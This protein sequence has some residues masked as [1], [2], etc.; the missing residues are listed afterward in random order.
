MNPYTNALRYSVSSQRIRHCAAK[1]QR[2]VAA[3][4]ARKFD[5][6][7]GGQELSQAEHDSGELF[8][9]NDDL[10]KSTI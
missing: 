3:Q 5:A 4:E 7:F 10:G 9:G 8:A 1:G 6:E 2:H